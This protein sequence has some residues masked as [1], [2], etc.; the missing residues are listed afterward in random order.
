[1]KQPPAEPRGD[2]HDR[3][4]HGHCARHSE[5]EERNEKPRSEGPFAWI[6][7]ELSATQE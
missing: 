6:G 2:M 3:E 1:M 5:R 4:R 7:L